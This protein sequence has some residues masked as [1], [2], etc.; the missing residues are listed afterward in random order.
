[1]KIVPISVALVDFM[2][3]D[4]SVVNAARVSF[5]KVSIELNEKDKKLLKYLADH[6]HWSPF[7]HTSISLRVKAPIFVARQLVKHQVG[8]VWNEVSRRYVDD[9]PEFFLPKEWRGKPENAKQGSSGVIKLP[10][11]NDSY[12]V[13]STIN[14]CLNLYQYLLNVGVAPEQARMVLPQNTMTEWI[15]TSNL[16]GFMRMYKERVSPGAQQETREIAEQVAPIIQ[17]L[18]PESWKALKN[19]STH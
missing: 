12:Y 17:A 6:S 19:A 3:T 10:D 2:G 9:E 16:V 13:E 1:M 8:F 11:E 15:W 14:A 5:N 7:A 18:F 4:L